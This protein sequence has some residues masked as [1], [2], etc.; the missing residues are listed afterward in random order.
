MPVA[1]VLIALFAV[2]AAPDAAAAETLV[3]TNGTIIDGT[4]GQPIPD[5][6]VVIEK[7]RIVRVGRASDIPVPPEAR[8]LDAKDGTILPGMIDSHV[9][10]TWIPRVRRRFLELG[11]TAVCDLGSQ[12]RRMSKFAQEDWNGQPVARGFRA[13]PIVT[14]PGGLPDA[15]IHENLNFEVAT[16]E[17][18][19]RGI[20]DLARRGADVIKLYLQATAGDSSYPM[21]DRARLNAIVEEG[22]AH[23]LLVRAH[24]TQLALLDLALDSGVDIIEHVP[25]VELNGEKLERE[26]EHSDDPLGD[27]FEKVVDPAYDTILPRI[28]KDKVIMVPTLARGLGRW[29]QSTEATPGQRV[30]A[31]AVLE[32]VRRFHKAGGVIALGTDYNYRVEELRPGLFRREIQ[33]LHAAGLAPNKVIEAATRHSAHV[34]GQGD[35]LGTIEA[36]KLADIVV[37]KGDPLTELAALEHVVFVIK[38]GDVAFRAKG[39]SGKE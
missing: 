26:L 35:D 30:L 12:I 29:Y 13:G 27:L 15:A 3:I 1:N 31:D 32:I 34:C 18:A 33:L 4:A 8:I 22:H 19:R 14:A 5:G 37:V 21:L 10:T 24:V 39:I 16:P 36:G 17:D 25:K 38:G 11:V 7:D 20:A 6:I 2:F 28:V 9:H 23:G